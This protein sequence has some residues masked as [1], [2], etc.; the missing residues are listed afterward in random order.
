MIVTIDGGVASGKSAVVPVF[1]VA[2]P[3]PAPVPFAIGFA[4]MRALSVTVCGA[5]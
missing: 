1:P 5:K 4:T 3:L 2:G